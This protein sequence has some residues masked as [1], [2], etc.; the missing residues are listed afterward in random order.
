MKRLALL[1]MALGAPVLAC[2]SPQQARAKERTA[3]IFWDY[4][5]DAGKAR[6]CPEDCV[7]PIEI[8]RVMYPRGRHAA[9]N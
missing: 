2:D 9:A 5:D 1:L 8:Y 7:G 4:L 6:V 3:R